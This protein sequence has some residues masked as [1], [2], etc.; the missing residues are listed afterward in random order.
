MAGYGFTRKDNGPTIEEFLQK[1][2]LKHKDF[3][4]NLYG[5]ICKRMPT[6]GGDR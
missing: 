4:R 6:D 5:L 3:G 1:I 2:K